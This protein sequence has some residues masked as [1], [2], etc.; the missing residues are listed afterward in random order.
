R[1]F[2]YFFAIVPAF[3]GTLLAVLIGWSGPVGGI[4]P[5]VILSGLL[6][7]VAAGDGIRFNRQHVVIAAWFGLLIIPPIM[8]GTALL[9]VPEL[10]RAFARPVQGRLPVIR[11]GWAMIRPQADE[12]ARTTDSK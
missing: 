8:T 11:I 2:V 5:L 4:A 12:R 7:V 6:A 1:Q 3:T 10:T 9:I